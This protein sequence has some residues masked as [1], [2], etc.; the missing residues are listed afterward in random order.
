MKFVNSLFSLVLLLSISCVSVFSQTY[1]R[2]GD[3][4]SGVW[5]ESGSPYNISGTVIVQKGKKLVIEPG[6]KIVMNSVKGKEASIFVYGDIEVNGAPNKPVVFDRDNSY[7]YWGTIFLKNSKNSRFE[8]CKISGGGNDLSNVKSLNSAL[9]FISTEITESR[10]KGVW[11]DNS[12]LNF[13]GCVVSKNR[14]T[15]IFVVGKSDLKLSNSVIDNNSRFGVRL[16]NCF[17]TVYNSNIINNR[18]VAFVV[19]TSKPLVIERSIIWGNRLAFEEYNKCINI[20]SS[21]IQSNICPKFDGQ[22]WYYSWRS[23]NNIGVP[24]SSPNFANDLSNNKFLSVD[25]VIGVSQITIGVLDGRATLI[26]PQ[27]VAK[28]NPPVVNNVQT[29]EEEVVKNIVAEDSQ[30]VSSDVDN[31]IPV[32]VAT[33]Q[34]RYALVIGNEDYSSFQTG[35]TS[36]SNVDFAINDARIFA[37]YC[38]K[39]LGVPDENVFLLENATATQMK[40]EINKLAKIMLYTKGKSE[41]FVYYAGHGIPHEATKESYILPVD[42]SSQNITDGVKLSWMY[43]KLNEFPSVKVLVFLDAC[44]SGGS[45]NK[46]LLAARGVKVKAN[47]EVIMGNCAVFT[48]SSNIQSS[49][50]YKEKSH[51]LFTYFLLKKLQ[52]TKGNISLKELND[53]LYEK[54]S[55]SSLLVNNKEQ[56]PKIIVSPVIKDSWEQ[57]RVNSKE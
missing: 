40:R 3:K 50:P 6:V 20:N 43:T 52:E 51:G 37:Q 19:N 46:G 24:S 5:T 53:Y 11:A 17:A 18:G 27:I 9:I 39:T 22:D 31:R 8:N 1:F 2:K 23:R 29:V 49:L 4:V 34:Y 15:G 38:R 54:V 14:S 30:I 47:D 13:N 57:I 26:N 48:A 55:L 7:G 16:E 45:R 28:N 41:V 12:T 35:L 36:E 10:G 42:V 56:T 33:S 44:F 21:I 25:C 32:G